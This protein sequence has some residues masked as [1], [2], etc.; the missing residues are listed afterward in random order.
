MAT[1]Q[2]RLDQMV[3]RQPVTAWNCFAKITMAP[4]CFLFPVYGLTACGAAPGL[5][6]RLKPKSLG[7]D[8]YNSPCVPFW[9]AGDAFAVL[10]VGAQAIAG[11]DQ[12]H[13]VGEVV[14]R[15]H[16]FWDSLETAMRLTVI[17]IIPSLKGFPGFT[18][19]DELAG[20]WD[21]RQSV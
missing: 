3:N 13:G 18:R 12:G 1:R 10:G 17:E 9:L 16:G 7:G 15:R 6:I 5:T 11:A 21:T 14:V 8:A 2:Q 4:T 20:D 19:P